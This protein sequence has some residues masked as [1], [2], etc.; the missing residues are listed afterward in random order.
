MGR[1]CGHRFCFKLLALAF[2]AASVLP[3]NAEVTTEKSASILIFPKVLFTVDYDTIIQVSNTSNSLVYAHC[4]YVDAQP[5]DPSLPAGPSNPPLW[6]EV[7]FDLLLTRQQP[8]HWVVSLGRTTDPFDDTCGV[9]N[10]EC[11]DAG[12]DPGRIPPVSPNFQGELKCVQVDQSGAPI[13]GNN[14]KGEATLLTAS[15]PADNLAPRDVSKY[16]AVGVLGLDSN[17]SDTT[18]CLGGVASS[19]CPAGAEYSGCPDT[20][21]LSHYAEGT[22]SPLLQEFNAPD[23]SSEVHTELT[24]VPCSQDFET[25]TPSR[26]RIQFAIY[27]EFEEPFSTSTTVTCWG[28]FRLADVNPVLGVGSLGTRF[29]QTRLRPAGNDPGFVAVQEEFHSVI[30]T[31]PQ[32][33]TRAAFNTHVIGERPQGDL[34]VIPEGP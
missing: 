2:F 18:L 9:N 4:F 6:Q 7:D 26:V 27:N 25:Q 14:M 29:I 5:E 16:N 33:A 1:M 17:D 3:A 15:D 12:F 23:M 10:Q 30:E 24:V 32:P 20:V 34:V 19:K 31:D 28:N 22:T 21:L 11:N 8:T 13:S